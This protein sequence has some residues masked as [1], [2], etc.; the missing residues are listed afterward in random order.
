MTKPIEE[1][2]D[3]KELPKALIKELL[4]VCETPVK[5]QD[6]YDRLLAVVVT[7]HLTGYITGTFNAVMELPGMS[8]L[9]RDEKNKL[10][11][12][13]DTRVREHLKKLHEFLHD[14]KVKLFTIH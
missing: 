10:S 12:T 14:D 9:T 2:S 13:R 6:F 1:P 3:M 8:N 4:H 11:A 7:A 5:P